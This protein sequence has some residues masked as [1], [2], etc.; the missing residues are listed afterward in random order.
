MLDT[1]SYVPYA[2]WQPVVGT[3]NSTTG[4][5]MPGLP[6]GF[7]MVSAEGY[8][9]AGWPV[10]GSFP[11]LF[12]SAPLTV[13]VVDAEN[14]PVVGIEVT[15]SATTYNGIRAVA[16]TDA[17]GNAHFVDIPPVTIGLKAITADGK[18][19]VGSV[20]GGS[21]TTATVVLAAFQPPVDGSPG[22]EVEDGTTGWTDSKDAPITKRSMNPTSLVKRAESHLVVFTNFQLALQTGHK[23]FHVPENSGSAYIEYLFQ[24]DE[25]PAG[26]F[27]TKY[28]DYFSIT[29]R[30]NDG[31]LTTLTRSM[32]ELG[33]GAFNI[34]GYTSWFTT[35]L[36]LSGTTSAVEYIV[37]VSNVADALFQSKVFVRKVGVCD[38]CAS[39]S[40]CPSLAKCQATCLAPATDS[41]AFYR[42][43]L[44]QTVPCG[45]AGYALAAG[46][47]ACNKFQNTKAELSTGA[48]AWFLSAEQCA[49]KA[50]VPLLSCETTCDV[51]ELTGWESLKGCY[52]GLGLCDLDAM[53]YVR[54]LETLDDAYH[55]E[56]LQAA[57]SS[58]HGCSKKIIGTIEK[59]IQD[60]MAAAGADPSDH[61]SLFDRPC[62]GGRK[63]FFQLFE[64][65]DYVDAEAAAKYIKQVYDTGLAYSTP[66]PISLPHGLL[67]LLSVQ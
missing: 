44:E 51:V 38:K 22:F 49:Q 29:I 21:E 25:I 15:A 18:I 58:L 19:G 52:A 45:A 13:K 57:V 20:A 39:C 65:E 53:D 28:N 24:T 4:I 10:F 50:L 42:A 59:G 43:C 60:K 55:K 27:G 56:A 16:T 32:N 8:D 37:A 67:A 46:E 11:L 34:S 17:E 64:E 26:Y 14:N 9:Q 61:K 33:R 2:N 6:A 63:E 31:K 1:T 7:I 62:I 66:R 48:V 54:I 23:S 5:D 35:Q 40:A 47:V 30:T 12:G 3:T 36:D 41:C